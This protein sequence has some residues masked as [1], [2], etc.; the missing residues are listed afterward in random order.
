MLLVRFPRFSGHNYHGDFSISPALWV[1]EME[2]LKESL[3]KGAKWIVSDQFRDC[4]L[5]AELSK[6]FEYYVKQKL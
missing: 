1:N 4:G 2:I 6:P 3:G 5:W